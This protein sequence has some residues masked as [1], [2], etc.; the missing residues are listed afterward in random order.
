[1]SCLFA[2]NK[3]SIKTD[4]PCEYLFNSV[5]LYTYLSYLISIS[6]SVHVFD[7][8]A[9]IKLIHTT[10]L[11]GSGVIDSSLLILDQILPFRSTVVLLLRFSRHTSEQLSTLASR[12]RQIDYSFHEWRKMRLIRLPLPI[13]WPSSFQSPLFATRVCQMWRSLAKEIPH[14]SPRHGFS[15]S[16]FVCLLSH[17]N[18]LNSYSPILSKFSG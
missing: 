14:F 3:E 5:G 17:G 12:L 16:R 9:P 2:Y 18:R 8:S 7:E 1:M 6:T 13:E 15:R 11:A 4:N 10:Q